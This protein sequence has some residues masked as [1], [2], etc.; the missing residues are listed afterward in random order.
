MQICP[1]QGLE[2]ELGKAGASSDMHPETSEF[3]GMGERVV[4][5]VL[6]AS[7]NFCSLGRWRFPGS[8]EGS[9]DLVGPAIRRCA[10]R[11]ACDRTL[12]TYLHLRRR[13]APTQGVSNAGIA[14]ELL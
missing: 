14:R 11:H 1:V 4:A 3:E 9:K 8:G 10:L 7:F 13:R 6:F 5:R 2:N 12:V